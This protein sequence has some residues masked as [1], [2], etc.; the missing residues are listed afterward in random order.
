M[1]N[2]Y[3][4]VC[5]SRSCHTHRVHGPFSDDDVIVVVVVVVDDDDTGATGVVDN[6]ECCGG[7]LL[8]YTF[9]LP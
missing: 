6:N 1:V 9:G 5:S 2:V 8:N 7:C 3:V 4:L